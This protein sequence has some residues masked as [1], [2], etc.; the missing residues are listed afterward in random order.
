MAKIYNLGNSAGLKAHY[1][2]EVKD[3]FFEQDVTAHVEDVKRQRDMEEYFGKANTHM[4][5]F[6]TIPDGIALKILA[7]HRLDIHDPAFNDNPMNMKRL[8]HIMLTEYRDLV[9]N[10]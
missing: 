6:A 2:F 4:R 5:K 1:D 3:N 8:K 7:D 9:I 10:T